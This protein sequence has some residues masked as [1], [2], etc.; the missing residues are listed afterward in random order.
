LAKETDPEE[1]K[2]KQELWKQ[3]FRLAVFFVQ[4]KPLTH[5]PKFGGESKQKEIEERFDL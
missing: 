1:R 4:A 5:A 2:N 3:F